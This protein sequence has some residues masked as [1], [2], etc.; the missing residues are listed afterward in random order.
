MFEPNEMNLPNFSLPQVMELPDIFQLIETIKIEEEKLNGWANYINPIGG[1]PIFTAKELN[2][3][4]RIYINTANDDVFIPNRLNSR[5]FN[6]KPNLRNHRFIFRG[7]KQHFPQILSSFSRNGNCK[8]L[9]NLKAEEFINLL[10]THPLFMML[11]RG[12]YLEPYKKPF[13]LE[14]NYYGLAQHYNFNTGLIDFT[15]DISAAAFFAVT[16]NCGNDKYEPYGG[17]KENPFG[18]IYVH[19]INPSTSF[20][21]NGYRTIGLQIYPRTAAQ[22]GIV[23]EEGNSFLPIE[24]TVTPLFFRH[25]IMNARKIFELMKDGKKLFPD[26]DLSPIAKEIL[27]SDEISGETFARNNFVNQDDFDENLQILKE[28]GIKVNWHKKVCFTKE[29]L[30]TYYSNVR[31]TLWPE[32]CSKIDFVSEKGEQLKDCLFNLPNNP[33][34]RQY[35]DSLQLELLQYHTFD[36]IFR[37]NKNK[38]KRKSV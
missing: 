22:H 10:R 6:L 19:E 38:I 23:F 25:D 7:Q 24:A 18:V 12:I 35:F 30:N 36:D 33:Y 20:V 4:D 15:T 8:L 3:S 14:M 32:F 2:N 34:Y 16:I 5:R 31:N 26:D 9:S 1:S 37:S 21:V 29:M 17:T 11:D 13:F 27:K 28:N